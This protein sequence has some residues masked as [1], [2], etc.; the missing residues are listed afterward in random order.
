MKSYDEVT[1][2]LLKRSD[3]YVAEQKH[4]RKKVI[5]LTTSV[6]CLFLFSLIGLGVWQSGMFETTPLDKTLE[7]TLYPGIKDNFDESKGESPDNP[8]ANNKIVINT[9]NGISAGR[10]NICLLVDD[11]VEMTL[12]EMIAYYGVDF[13]PDVPADIKP[14]P[15]NEQCGIYKRNDGTSEVYWDAEILNYSNEDFTR[16]V[17]LEVAKGHIPWVDY[18]HFDTEDETSVINNVELKIGK[19]D[20]GYYYTEFLY[21]NVGFTICTKGLTQDEFVAIIMSIIK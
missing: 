1:N 18:M 3:R 21:N 6:C 12:D 5:S 13:V 15:E 11:F 16:S 14:W 19:T 20:E 2:N 4:K 9:L 10:M 8:A 7:D 17:N